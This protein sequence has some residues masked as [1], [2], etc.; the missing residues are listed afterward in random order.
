MRWSL[1]AVFKKKVAELI[2]ESKTFWRIGEVDPDDESGAQTVVKMVWK[3]TRVYS[4]SVFITGITAI[5]VTI[6]FTWGDTLPFVAW[7]PANFPYGY[8]VN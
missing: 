3:G 4:L 1:F 5:L 2:A 7:Y 8:E 6:I